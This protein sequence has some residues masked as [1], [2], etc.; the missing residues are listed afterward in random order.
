MDMKRAKEAWQTKEKEARQRWQE[1][2]KSAIKETTL[3]A[4]EPQ[5]QRMLDEY[6]AKDKKR[7]AEHEVRQ[8]S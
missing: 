5:V 7:E 1:E 2:Q 6:R 8:P 3:K 4:L